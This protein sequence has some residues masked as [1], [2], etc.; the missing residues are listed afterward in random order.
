VKTR[1]ENS[2]YQASPTA[3][4]STMLAP[5][6]DRD[7]ILRRPRGLARTLKSRFL[8]TVASL[9]ASVHWFRRPHGE[10]LLPS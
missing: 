9:I 6:M 4:C 1:R 10:M 5:A 3:G 7:S 2:S 8:H